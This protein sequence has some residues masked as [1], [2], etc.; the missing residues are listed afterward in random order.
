M[1]KKLSMKQKYTL[2]SSVL[3][4]ICLIFV[5]RLVNLQF[6]PFKT[7]DLRAESEYIIETKTIQALRGNICDRNGTVLVTSSY[8]YDIIFD[9]NSMPDDFIA[10]NSSILSV[11]EILNNTHNNEFRTA[12]LY[13]FVGE[14]PN[15]NYNAEALTDGTSVSSALKR[16]LKDLDMENA[17]ATE[18][19]NYFVKRWKLNSTDKNGQAIFTNE[20]I[21]ALL[22]VRY[23]M[24]R[25][26]FSS[27]APYC[28]ASGVQVD[29]VAYVKEL[30]IQ[31]VSDRISSKRTYTYPGYASHVLG[32][33]GS[34]TAETWEY[35]KELGYNMSDL[36]GIDGCEAEFEEYL[37]GKDGVLT[38]KRN[39]K[40]EIVEEKI[41]VEPI[42]GKDVWLTIDIETQIATE[43]ALKQYMKDFNK[44]EGASVAMDPNTG[45]ILAIASYPTYD[46]TSFNKD[47][48]SLASNEHLPLLNRACYAV[49]APG[50]TFKVAVSLAGLEQHAISSSTKITCNHGY[51]HHGI[52]IDC[53]NHNDYSSSSLNVVEALTFSCNAFFIETGYDLLD[54][55]TMTQYCTSLGLGQST[56]IEIPELV[57]QIACPDNAI[58]WDSF[59]EASSYIG[60]SIHQYSPLQ[61]TSYISTVATGGTRYS[62]HLL[63]SVREFSGAVVTEYNKQVLSTVSIS[64]STLNTIKTGMRNMI[65]NSPTSTWN[66]YTKNKI[67]VTVC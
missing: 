51:K 22:R 10:F 66:M 46:L 17:S 26:Q 34:I 25:T 9:Y 16:M 12:D 67:G 52:N 57:G 55:D 4:I 35:Y 41:T 38:I 62:A 61:I 53:S 59:N 19:V 5:A 30:N 1:H 6:N 15:L 3:I 2:L 43:D 32:R 64:A 44:N 28:I 31:G 29:L 48:N 21:S 40:G 56:G 50:S 7:A 36:V 39:A 45:D 20:Q 13:P 33:V 65:D 63:H 18:L 58:S 54:I 24:L 49:Y 23:D 11:I 42:A 37:R 8:A 14:Y 27:V 60:Q 47:Y